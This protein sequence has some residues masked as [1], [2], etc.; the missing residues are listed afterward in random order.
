MPN[1]TRTTEGSPV[2]SENEPKVSTAVKLIEE[3]RTAIGGLR[4][5]VEETTRALAELAKVNAL[6][7]SVADQLSESTFKSSI[8]ATAGVAPYTVLVGVIEQIGDLA[9]RSVQGTYELR[10]QLAEC[11]SSVAA[12]TAAVG[13]ADATLQKLLTLTQVSQAG[14]TASPHAP[15]EVEVRPPAPAKVNAGAVAAFW[16]A[17]VP[18]AGGFKN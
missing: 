16:A 11:A 6:F 5:Q 10:R 1:T 8:Q 15:I 2:V 12:T 13:E 18:K 14:A 9:K 17:V 3:S 4:A 7:E